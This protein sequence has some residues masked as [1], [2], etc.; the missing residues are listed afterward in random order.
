MVFYDTDTM[1]DTSEDNRENVLYTHTEK[2]NSHMK[3]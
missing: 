2:E 3:W 1:G